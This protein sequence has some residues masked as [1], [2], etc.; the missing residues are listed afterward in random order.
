MTA[1]ALG[2]LITWTM[3]LLWTL[4][5]PRKLGPAGLGTVMSAWSITGIFGILLGLGTKNYLVRMSVVDP[6]A[7]P[8]RIGTTLVARTIFSPL[9]FGAA[10]VYGQIAA[11]DN[12]VD[13][14]QQYVDAI[15]RDHMARR[16]T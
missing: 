11:A 13:G 15:R 16:H 7:A 2:Q 1:L 6:D 8:R 5:V 4:V 14:V 9:V 3:T 12:R 10:V